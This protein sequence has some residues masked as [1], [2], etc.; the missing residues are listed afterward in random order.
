MIGFSISGNRISVTGDN[1][2]ELYGQIYW[3][4]ATSIMHTLA[5]HD[6]DMYILLLDYPLCIHTYPPNKTI[7]RPHT[8]AKVQVR[9]MVAALQ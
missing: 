4:S 6:T 9:P 8:L 1:G 7:R 2:K 3:C 5:T